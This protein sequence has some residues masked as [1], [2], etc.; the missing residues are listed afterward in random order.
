MSVSS[1]RSQLRSQLRES[2]STAILE[3]AED[4]IAAKGL[5]G[6]P[7]LQIAKR[8][9][10]AVGTLYNYFADRDALIAALFE[11]RRATL[12]PQLRAAVTAGAGLAFEP[13][14]RAFVR[15]V[16]AAIE[17]HRKYVKVVIE[18]EHAKVSG[19]KASE[20]IANAIADL[21]KVGIQEGVVAPQHADLSP[22]VITGALKALLFKRISANAKLELADADSLVTLFLDGAR[23]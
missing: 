16:F 7:L 17:A 18:T 10:V 13:R 19:G 15:D 1:V 4:L 3:A 23:A 21:V 22:I 8:A 9:G 11:M 12:R 20:D 14:L 2:V 5:A 6:A